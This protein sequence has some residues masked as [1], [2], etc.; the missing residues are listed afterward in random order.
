V[1][2]TAVLGQAYLPRVLDAAVADAL[3]IA[4]G[5]LIEGARGSG[6]T[7]TALNAAASYVFLDREDAQALLQ[8][9]PQTLLDGAAPRL[10]DEWPLAP[11]LWNM[12]R[13]RIDASAA[14]GLFLL[15]GSA[16]PADDATRHT[17]AAR[18]LRLRQRTLTWW[19]KAGGPAQ[20][21]SLEA[22]FD[23]RSP[24][25]ELAQPGLGDVIAPLLRPGFPAM[26]QFE[27]RRAAALLGAYA[28]EI[29]RGDMP[30]LARTRHDPIV[31]EQLM[32]AV[33][34]NSAAEV[35]YTTLAKDLRTVAPAITAETVSDYLKLLQRLFV[36]EPQRAWAPALRSRAVLRTSPK[37]HLVD[38]ALAATLLGAGQS[39][40]ER[41]LA[42]L[43]T[44]FE[45]AAVHDLM[46]FAARLG[47]EVRHYRD[48]NGHE[49]DAV[50]VL[51][52]GRWG[53]VEVKLGGGQIAAGAASL[54]RALDQ[55]DR[56]AVGEPAF[57]L[58]VTGTGPTLAMEDGTVTCPLAALAP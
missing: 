8:V 12:V 23:G 41:D 28:E 1:D 5:V 29:S 14:K 50:I 16:V 55:I 10:L 52:D 27:G 2:T 22:L 43:G 20:G 30:R 32:A 46:A 3:E 58:V 31:I 44:L 36:V 9:A 49:I 38:P 33:A 37:L 48:S 25:P 21:V 39:R 17:G 45:S 26:S 51:R 6:K 18:V 4:G 7:M 15:T 56:E 35:A 42:T 40:L 47:G 19:E 13:R 24:E 57:R 34:R 11:G 54:A 53:A